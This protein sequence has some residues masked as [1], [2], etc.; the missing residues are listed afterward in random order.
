MAPRL[1]SRLLTPNLSVR[2]SDPDHTFQ[3]HDPEQIANAL[4]IHS[5][6][7]AEL[8]KEAAASSDIGS[9][10]FQGHDSS[11]IAKA[12][13]S[14]VVSHQDSPWSQNFAQPAARVGNLGQ[15]SPN[16]HSGMMAVTASSSS[17]LS[18]SSMLTPVFS[19]S[20]LAH[21][22]YWMSVFLCIV[23]IVSGLFLLFFG[24][25]SF[26]WGCNLG[27][28]ANR[29]DEKAKKPS[30][31]G[32]LFAGPPLAGGVGGIAVGFLF[33]SFLATVVTSAICVSQ[34][35]S[36]SSTSFFIIWLLPG[37]LGAFFA[38]H[39]PLFARAFTGLLSSACLTLIVTAMFGIHTLI[40]R[41]I[42][43][44]ICTSLIT[45][46]LLL[47]RRNAIHFHLLNICTSFIGGV[48]FLDGVALFAPSRAS[49]DSWINL[50]V[51]L[52]A[53]DGSAPE[54]SASKK[55]GTS[56]F[57]GFIAG[58]VLSAVV[59]FLFEFLF[60]KHAAEDPDMEWNNYLG[61]FTQRLENHESSDPQDRAGSF[62]PAPNAWQKISRAFATPVR[63]A[64]YGNI[65][66]SNDPEKSPLTDLPGS[67][68]R[69]QARRS[70]S[71]K[72]RG[73]P[74]KFEALDK[75][76]KDLELA[77][78]DSDDATDYDSD[79]SLRKL[80]PGKMVSAKSILSKADADE[81][82][83]ELKPLSASGDSK[84]DNSGALK[85]PRP[86]SYRTNS[87]NSRGSTVSGLSGTTVNSASEAS[88]LSSTSV[89]AEKSLGVYRDR[90]A[91]SSPTRPSF[92]RHTTMSP[93][94]PF[95]TGD[96]QPATPLT[97]SFPATPSLVNAIT[98]IQAAQA[99][100]KAWYETRQEQDPSASKRSSSGLKQGQTQPK[101]SI[102]SVEK[103]STNDATTRA[104]S[105]PAHPEGA[106][107]Q[108][109][110]GKEVKGDPKP[111]T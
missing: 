51:L 48:T 61:S 3:G 73:G 54:A 102:R 99:Q 62:E 57:K 86:P 78:T 111:S 31:F 110:W 109:W 71:A 59:G 30:R 20:A 15:S 49:S 97:P 18:S 44:V 68:K 79:S 6:K 4:A 104:A 19:I 100:A 89:P 24:W 33:F 13:Q 53:I 41:A 22:Q 47:P 28:S 58:A 85:L 76:S 106:S 43:I 7:M 93:P 5:Q 16:I 87:S 46:P 96:S 80:N 83:D 108:S 14:Y 2:D 64:A 34:V 9:S 70:R 27:T 56:V 77:D 82:E 29:I 52:F 105:P 26:F 66:A 67:K 69:R 36:V 1:S 23:W 25:A 63:P 88:R 95:P 42:F 101:S 10:S 55:W 45:A 35:K 38:G 72:V 21:E 37:L 92:S 12:I 74:A 81:L 17:S 65:S 39:W 94:P 50:W 8:A 11:D 60:H 107:F 98:R 91:L 90:D 40:I 84:F 103:D 32:P 75:H